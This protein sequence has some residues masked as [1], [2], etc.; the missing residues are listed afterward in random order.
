ME[1]VQNMRRNAGF[2]AISTNVFKSA[3]FDPGALT[4]DPNTLKFTLSCSWAEIQ[5]LGI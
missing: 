1:L 2:P 4:N 5:S 3:L